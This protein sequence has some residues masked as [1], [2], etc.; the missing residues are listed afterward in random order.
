MPVLQS[1][2]V[3]RAM[4]RLDYGGA[5]LACLPA[6]LVDRMQSVMNAAA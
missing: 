5:T 6:N 2:V 4:T 3:L 1:L